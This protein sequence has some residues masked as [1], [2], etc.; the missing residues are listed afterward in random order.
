MMERLA[1]LGFLF[2]CA[3]RAF[4]SMEGDI[5]LIES[6]TKNIP[7]MSVVQEQIAED[8]TNIAY[9]LSRLKNY[10]GSVA[11]TNMSWL[12]DFLT[13]SPSDPFYTEY[14]QFRYL[15]RTTGRQNPANTV[16]PQ[17]LTSFLTFTLGQNIDYNVSS[18]ARMNEWESFSPRILS[19]E[20]LLPIPISTIGDIRCGTSGL[21]RQCG[22]RYKRR[23]T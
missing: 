23:K 1:V 9:N 8:T 12:H 13:G 7:S 2:G 22:A 11:V 10:V 21:R 6:H 14:P 3:L 16:G 4:G 15:S 5:A 20:T 17:S 19:G 18:V